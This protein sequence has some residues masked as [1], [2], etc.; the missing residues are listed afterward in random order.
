MVQ[1]TILYNRHIFYVD[2]THIHQ[3]ISFTIIG[4]EKDD[5]FDINNDLL[6]KRRDSTTIRR[7]YKPDWMDS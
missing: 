4:L 3:H 2:S 1:S 5:I 6:L 7:I